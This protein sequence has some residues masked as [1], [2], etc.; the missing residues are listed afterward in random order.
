MPTY[1]QPFET[2]NIPLKNSLPLTNLDASDAEVLG[3]PNRTNAVNV[4]PIGT[5]AK[6]N[7]LP[8]TVGGTPLKNKDGEEVMFELSKYTSTNTYLDEVN[9]SDIDNNMSS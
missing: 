1:Q 5:R 9:Q 4:P 2:P 8:R 3:G 6:E 7:P